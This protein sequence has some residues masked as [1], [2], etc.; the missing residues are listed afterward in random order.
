[1]RLRPALNISY[2]ILLLALLLGSGYETAVAESSVI[3]VSVEYTFGGQMTFKALVQSG[4]PVSEAL[5]SFR[6]EGESD[7]V[8]GTASVDPEGRLIFT[9]DLTMRPLRA[10]SQVD[11]WFTISFQDG[12]HFTS[13][14]FVFRYMDNRF[15]WQ[16]LDEGRFH[17]SWYDG[18]L[19][20][21]QTVLDVAK[22]GLDHALSL[23]TLK[24]P[25]DIYIYAY[26]SPSELQA[27]LR[28]AGQDWVAGHADPDLHL[29]VVSLPPGPD[30]RLEME[31]QIPHELMHI[32]L[33]QTLDRGYNNLPTW[34]NEGLSSLVQLYPM[35]EYQVILENAI[36]KEALIPISSLCQNFPVDASSTYLSYAESTS[37][38]RY[39]YRRFGKT[40][41]DSLVAAYS[42]GVDCNRGAET[43]L[44]ES[45]LRLEDQ[46][47]KESFNAN[48]ALQSIETLL[49]WFVLLFVV[50]VVP[51]ALSA[52]SML[53]RKPGGAAG[54]SFDAGARATVEKP[55][56]RG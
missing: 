17:V 28:L 40:G 10:F 46:W 20:F 48:P 2:V 49:P 31:R 23:L 42:N 53:A 21:A 34:L 33:Y 39:L 19:A 16:T 54:Q 7:T 47:L 26:A 36:Q 18:D 4:S 25:D 5:V 45:L 3:D 11:Y 8:V 35:P 43:A 55:V 38:T 32:L 9:Y 44:G 50:L 1:M 37:F 29:M 15:T 30:R 27:T 12:Q 13:P 22:E 24:V 51:L 6:P 52:W 56:L 41:L 14:T